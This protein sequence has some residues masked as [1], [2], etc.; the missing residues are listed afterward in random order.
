MKM[1]TRYFCSR[2]ALSKKND[3]YIACCTTLK[4]V[5]Y[6]TSV[7]DVT[8]VSCLFVAHDTGPFLT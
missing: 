5:I 3:G 4:T 7:V 8:T 6:S 1:V 2:D